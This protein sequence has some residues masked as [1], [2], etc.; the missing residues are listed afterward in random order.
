MKNLLEL[1]FK[2]VW[3]VIRDLII[4]ALVVAFLLLLICILLHIQ[5]QDIMNILKDFICL[6]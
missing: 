6:I 1:I 2:I 4:I 5:P 3:G